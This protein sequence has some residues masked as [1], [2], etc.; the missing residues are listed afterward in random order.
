MF[1]DYHFLGGSTL[2]IEAVRLRKP[3]Q[4]DNGGSSSPN[5]G[6]IELTGHLGDVMKESAKIALTVAKNYLADIEP[7]NSFLTEHSIHIHFP[8]VFYIIYSSNALTFFVIIYC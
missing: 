3:A 4:P 5:I 7:Q 1:Y 2:Y 8:E 6:T